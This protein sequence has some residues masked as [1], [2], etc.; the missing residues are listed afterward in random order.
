MNGRFFSKCCSA[1]LGSGV[2][3]PGRPRATTPEEDRFLALS[4]RR[5]TTTAPYF[6]HHVFTMQVCMHQ[7]C[8]FPS[9]DDSEGTAYA[10]QENNAATMGFC[11]RFIL[12][13]REQ[14]TRYVQH[15]QGISLGGHTMCSMEEPQLS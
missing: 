4:A 5:R 15:C 1:T 7:L 11:S 8:A 3:V 2:H 12:I 14:R 10:G 13:W 6:K 9:T